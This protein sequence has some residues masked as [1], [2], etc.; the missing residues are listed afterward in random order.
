MSSGAALPIPNASDGIEADGD[1]ASD[2]SG[3]APVD[4]EGAGELDGDGELDGEGT[5]DA[6]ASVTGEAVGGRGGSHWTGR[7]HDDAHDDRRPD[8]QAHDEAATDRR[9]PSHGVG[10]YQYHWEE[11]VD[12]ASST[13]RRP[14]AS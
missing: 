5:G 3:D 4:G 7:Q 11:G 2:S 1:A 10:A 14:W 13:I 8:E 6:V 12:R 9:F